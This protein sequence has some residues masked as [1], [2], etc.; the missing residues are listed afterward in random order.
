M[1]KG[2]V[3]SDTL[4]ILEETRMGIVKQMLQLESDAVVDSSINIPFEFKNVPEGKN[5][6]DQITI[7]SATVRTW[8]RLKPLL[9]LVENEDY[10]TLVANKDQ[11]FSDELRNMMSKYDNLLL[12]IVYIGI[13][14]KEGDMPKWFKQVLQDSC[15]WEDIYILLNAI[16]FR[17]GYTSFT[18]SIIALK[19]VSPLSEEEIIALQRNKEKWNHKAVLPS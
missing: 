9:A 14:N 15:T 16:L 12:E 18:S 11:D 2:V 6:G 3:F 4:Y 19:A 13:H 10:K 8:F 5:V 1:I 7:S 17:I